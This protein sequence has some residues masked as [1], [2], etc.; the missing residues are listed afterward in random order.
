MFYYQM[1]IGGYEN[2]RKRTRRFCQ[3]KIR[4]G[5]V[6]GDYLGK[7]IISLIMIP[8]MRKDVL[9]VFYRSGVYLPDTSKPGIHLLNHS[10][11]PNCWTYTYRGHTLFLPC[12]L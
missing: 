3:K 7:Y 5:T 8:L 1:I 12:V 6:I 4:I 10:C 11:R 9:N 2:G